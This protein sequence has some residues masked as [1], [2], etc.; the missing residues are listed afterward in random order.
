MVNA[1]NTD[2]I[3]QNTFKTEGIITKN[4]KKLLINFT[5]RYY[6]ENATYANKVL[7]EWEK[8]LVRFIVLILINGFILFLSFYAL[9]WV[10]PTISWIYIGSSLS[11]YPLAVIYLGLI[12]WFLTKVYWYA[13]QGYKEV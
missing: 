4:L 13:K 3:N 1:F 11:Q 12:S 5:R 9:L 8:K 6:N 2:S 10:F 7:I